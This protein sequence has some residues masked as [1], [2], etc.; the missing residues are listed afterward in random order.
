MSTDRPNRM[1]GSSLNAALT[2]AQSI[3]EAAKR[4]A[5]DVDAESDK[6]RARAREAGYQEGFQQG[7]ADAAQSAVRLIEQTQSISERLSEE[8]ARLGIAVCSSIIGEQVHIDPNVIAKI[9]RKA[10]KESVVGDTVTL[11]VNPADEPAVAAIRT[12]L[13]KI[14]GGAE[15]AF[16]VDPGITRGG[17]IIR[18]EF[19]EV[20]ATVEALV[21]SIAVRL[22][23]SRH[24]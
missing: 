12:D 9:A 16:E 23:V 2:E 6:I 4:R 3:V 22:G 19:G 15:V 8:A 10:L 21:E 17:C 24:G 14:S 18:T 13:K 11:V 5:A 7:L 1:P 20:D